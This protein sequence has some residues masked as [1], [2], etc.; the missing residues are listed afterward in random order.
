MGSVEREWLVLSKNR[1]YFGIIHFQFLKTAIDHHPFLVSFEPPIFR[2]C[3]Y[4][5]LRGDV[6][7]SVP[8]WIVLCRAKRHASV[9]LGSNIPPAYYDGGAIIEP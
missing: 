2:Y 3:R 6:Q 9:L 4:R 7:I 8:A 5:T 1:I